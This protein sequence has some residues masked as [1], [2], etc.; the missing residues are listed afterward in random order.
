MI[1]L[2]IV[3]LKKYW[4]FL[5]LLLIRISLVGFAS[6]ITFFRHELSKSE[7]RNKILALS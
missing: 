7:D 3:L 5:G 6:C 4:P 1:Q 2:A